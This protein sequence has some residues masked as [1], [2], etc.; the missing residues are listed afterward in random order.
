MPEIFRRYFAAGYAADPFREYED[1]GVYSNSYVGYAYYLTCDPRFLPLAAKELDKL[2][3]YAAPLA[4]PGDINERLYNPYAPA[5]TF[6]GV[7]RLIWALDAARQAGVKIPPRPIRQQRTAVALYKPAGKE[8]AATLWG[9]ERGLAVLG[10]DGKLFQGASVKSER[11]ASDVQPFDRTTS[12]FEV[13]L[14]RLTVPTASPSGYYVLAPRLELAV[15]DWQPENRPLWNAS[16][17][18]ELKAGEVIYLPVA[19]GEQWLTLEAAAPA[20]LKVWDVDRT[21]AFAKVAGTRAEFALQGNA[22]MVRIEATGKSSWLRIAERQAELCWVSPLSDAAAGPV[23]TA[24]QTAAVLPNRDAPDLE[25]PY[26]AGRF[27]QAALVTQGRALHLPDTVASGDQKTH[28]VDRRQGTIEFW[29]RKLWDERLTAQRPL[30]LL[31]NGD[32][33]IAM[34]AKLPVDEWAHVALVWAPY[35]GDPERTIT[36]TYV[37][38]RDLANYR[39]LN[40]EGYSSVRPSDLDK[41]VKLLEE[42]VSKAAPGTAFAIDE[43]RVSKSARYADLKIAFGPQQTFNP[44]HF[45]PPAGPF[46]VDSDTLLLW[47]FDGNLKSAAGPAGLAEGRFVESKRP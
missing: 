43:L 23:P 14:H 15:L 3:P 26:L 30:P 2:F 33:T 34:P 32:K 11:F 29:V 1:V 19:A 39:S 9:F 13:F 17:P 46:E 21:P 28:L 36:Y 41:P 37:N 25:R 6:A 42:F 10:P 7:P 44:F 40:W 47:H 45:D 38:G 24:A 18:L 16:R 31:T 4:Q 22:G 12:D 8:L 20:G 35:R 27:G 5:K